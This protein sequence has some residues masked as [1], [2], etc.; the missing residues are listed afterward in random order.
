LKTSALAAASMDEA[1]AVYNKF[2]MTSTV[3]CV[4]SLLVG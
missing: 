1:E 4:S 3:H 2:L